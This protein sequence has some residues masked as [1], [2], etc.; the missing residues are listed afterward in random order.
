MAAQ[1][2]IPSLPAA[3]ADRAPW[4]R[5]RSAA[6]AP[7]AA[8]LYLLSALPPALSAAPSLSNLYQLPLEWRDDHGTATRLAQWRGQT[9]LVTMAYSSCREICSYSLHRVGQ[10]QQSAERAG[11][12]VNVVV[13]SYDPN[14]DDPASW[15]TY[16]RHHHLERGD[17]HFLTGNAAT[18]RQ[19]AQAFNFPY[20]FMDDHVVHDFRILVVGPDGQISKT[21]SWANRND[22]L[23]TPAAPTC[24]SSDS[25]SC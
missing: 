6:G 25:G 22:D 23:L 12:H 11:L 1:R 17:W 15:S 4:R 10:L 14:V 16:R 7:C 24:R 2:M 19:F 8:L 9:L 5:G 3:L 18:T 20:W 13:I 21:L